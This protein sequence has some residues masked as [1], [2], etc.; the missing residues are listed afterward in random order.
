MT[1]Q[2]PVEHQQIQTF[3]ANAFQTAEDRPEQLCG[4]STNKR[5][6]YTAG[7]RHRT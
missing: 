7:V 6:L 1:Y 4:G 2:G 5:R 3:S